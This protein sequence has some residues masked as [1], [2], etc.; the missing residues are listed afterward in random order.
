M[1]TALA[2]LAAALTALTAAATAAAH[3]HISPPVGL[4]G[5][6]QAFT[7]SVPTEKEDART[8]TIELIPREGFSIGSVAPAPGWTI[9]V[10]KTGESDEAKVGKVTWSGGDVPSGQAAFLQFLGSGEDAGTHSVEVRQTYS[11]GTVVRWSGGESSESPAPT[12]E[13]RPSLG[14]GSG[15]PMLG[16]VALVVAGLALLVAVAGALSG[17]GG[18]AI[19]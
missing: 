10:D 12:V 4:T 2:L 19:A 14:G 3:A 18:R 8:T 6:S 5:G 15:S 7:L 13:L 11:D 16:I 17:R 1:R 9:S